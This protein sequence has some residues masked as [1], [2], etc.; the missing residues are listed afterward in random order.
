[1]LESNKCETMLNQSHARA[2]RENTL[3]SRRQTRRAKVPRRRCPGRRR[4]TPAPNS[5]TK[6]TTHIPHEVILNNVHQGNACE[7]G[8]ASLTFTSSPLHSNMDAHNRGAPSGGSKRGREADDDASSN[9]A[10]PSSRT[11]A[12]LGTTYNL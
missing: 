5:P 11:S 10:P 1:M 3:I 7:L 2:T 9:A 12:L 8:I 6:H 4:N